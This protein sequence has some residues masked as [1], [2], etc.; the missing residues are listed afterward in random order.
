MS[1][2]R[3]RIV[4]VLDSSDARCSD[5]YVTHS[6]HGPGHDQMCCGGLDGCQRCLDF[7]ADA[8]LRELAA[9]LATR[10]RYEAALRQIEAGLCSARGFPTCSCC[11]KVRAQLAA[12][13][14]DG[15]P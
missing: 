1:D 14:G 15:N 5:F 9:L 10:A 2:L 6:T 13:Y 8:V 4:G 7:A 12:A 3:E 11:A